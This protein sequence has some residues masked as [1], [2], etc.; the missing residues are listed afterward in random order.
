VG[1]RGKRHSVYEIKNV[2]WDQALD[3]VLDVNNLGKREDGT[4]IRIMTKDTIKGLEQEDEAK[5]R[6]VKEG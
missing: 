3:V 5:L 1:A 6:D 4:I 2:P